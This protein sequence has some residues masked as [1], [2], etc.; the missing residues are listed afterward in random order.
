MPLKKV[1]L[2][3]VTN[4]AHKP[5]HALVPL[6]VLS[7]G[8][9]HRCSAGTR[10]EDDM[11]ESVKN[12]LRFVECGRLAATAWRLG[13]GKSAPQ[14]NNSKEQNGITAPLPETPQGGGNTNEAD[15]SKDDQPQDRGRSRLEG[16]FG[17][18]LIAACNWLLEHDKL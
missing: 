4:M 17:Q 10:F 8:N 2:N 14:C 9:T 15:F 7:R 11:V 13:T 12:C 1:S 18:T 16:R 3:K 5:Y 6:A